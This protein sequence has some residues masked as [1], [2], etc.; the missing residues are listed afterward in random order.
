MTEGNHAE[1]ATVRLE[2]ELELELTMLVEMSEVYLRA[3]RSAR[4]PPGGGGV[5]YF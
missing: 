1:Y 2:L 4:G 5:D 3:M